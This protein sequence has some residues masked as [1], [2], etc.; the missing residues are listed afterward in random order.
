MHKNNAPTFDKLYQVIKGSRDKENNTIL[1]ADKSVLQHLIVAY[2]AG[3]EVDLLY[4]LSH[5]LTPVRVALAET[6]G[7]LKTGQK[8]LLADVI[9]EGVECPST[10]ESHGSSC[11]LIDGVGLVVAVGKP[12]DAKTFGDY[13]KSFQD[14]VLKTGSRFDHIHV[15]FDRYQK[16]LSNQA[17]ARGAPELLALFVALSRT[18]TCQSRQAGQTF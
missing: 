1:R 8:A 4:I 16:I 3:R 7:K 10:I 18:K 14:A 9:V 5:K 6:N 13:G 15:I 2:K 17:P 12:A 11:L